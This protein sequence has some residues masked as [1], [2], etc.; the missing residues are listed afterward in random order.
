MSGRNYSVFLGAL[1]F[2]SSIITASGQQWVSQPVNPSNVPGLWGIAMFDTGRGVAVGGAAVSNGLSGVVRRSAGNDTWSNVPP[3]NFSPALSTGFAFWSGACSRRSSGAAWI[4]GQNGVLYKSV[5]YGLNW[6]RKTSGISGTNSLFDIYFKTL[7]EGM[8]VGAAG[9]AYYTSDGGDNWTAL[10]SGTS[11]ALYAVHTAGSV[12]YVSGANN[13]MLAFT[14]PATWT[15]LGSSLASSSSTQIEGLHFLDDNTGHYSGY[16]SSGSTHVWRTTNGGAS[17]SGF[18]VEPPVGSSTFYSSVFFL[19]RN[20]GWVANAFDPVAGTTNGGTTWTT[21]NPLGGGT[22]AITRLDFV[23]QQNG[24]ASGGALG[25]GP[26]P[27]GFI[28]KYTGPPPAPDIAGSDTE[29]DFGKLSCVLN[30]DARFVLRNTGQLTLVV[31]AG[32]ITLPSTFFSLVSPA[33]PLSIPPGDSAVVTLRWKPDSTFTGALA[34]DTVIAVSNDPDQP[35]WA[36]L[37]KGERDISGMQLSARNINFLPLCGRSF[38]DTVLTAAAIGNVPPKII[39]FAHLAG[40]TGVT[41]MSPP[42]GSQ[43]AGSFEMSFRLRTSKLGALSGTYRLLAGDP[44]CPMEF[45]IDFMAHHRKNTLTAAPA[46]LEFGEVCSG[47]TREMNVYLRNIGNTAASISDRELVSGIDAF[48]NL[49]PAGFGPIPPDSTRQYTARFALA[50]SDTGVI[51]AVYRLISGPCSDTLLLTMRGRAVSAALSTAPASPVRLGPISIGQTEERAVFFTNR[52]TGTMRITGMRLSPGS[53]AL[54]LTN[55]PAMPL[56]LKPGEESS[57]SINFSPAR[58]ETSNA[59]L[60]FIWDHPCLDS[61]CLNVIAQSAAAASITT[62][63]SFDFGLQ[64]CSP[65]LRDSFIVRSMGPGPLNLISFSIDGPD[66]AHFRVLNPATPALVE[67][68]DSIYIMVEYSSRQE[69]NSTATL[70]VSHNDASVNNAS[71]VTLTGSRTVT[72]FTVEGDSTTVMS[73]CLKQEIARF[74]TIRNGSPRPLDITE[75]SIAQGGSAWN[76]AG[77]ALPCALAPGG[78]ISFRLTFRPTSG[79]AIDGLVRIVSKPCDFT[80]VLKVS[81]DGRNSAIT[82]IPASINFSTVNIGSV[83][84]RSA[85]I[86]NTGQE[87]VTVTAVFLQPAVPA[88]YLTSGASVP[89]TLGTGQ[90]RSIELEFRPTSQG[91]LFGKL[92]VATSLPCPDTLCATTLG[93]ARSEGIAFDRDSIEA[94]HDACSFTTRCET[95]LLI[96]NSAR[97]VTVSDISLLPAGLFTLDP[98]IATPFELRNGDTKLLNICSDPGFTGEKHARLAVRSNDPNFPFIELPIAAVRDSSGITADH[99][100]LDFGVLPNC[101][102]DS[103]LTVS[104]RNTGTIDDTLVIRRAPISPFRIYSTGRIA[105]AAAAAVGIDVVFEPSANGVFS[106]TMVVTSLS[107]NRDIAMPL[108][109]RR[110]TRNCDVTPSPLIFSGVAVGGSLIKD[111]KARNLNLPSARI[112]GVRIEPVAGPFT[113]EG[114]LPLSLD[115]G[116]TTLLP[117][118]FSPSTAGTASGAACVIFDLPCA[119]TICVPLAGETGE[120]SLGFTT[121]PL[122]FGSLAQ[123]ESATRTDTLRNRGSSP[124][125]LQSSMITGAGAAGF[126]I[127]DPVVSAELLPAGGARSFAVR[128]EPRTAPDGTI[129]ASLVVSTSD[130]AQPTSELPLQGVRVTQLVPDI[131]EQAFGD[132]PLGSPSQLTIPVG[133]PGTSPYTI[134]SAVFD[135]E[136]SVSP[137]PPVTIQPGGAEQFMLT[138]TPSSPG[139]KSVEGHLIIG[140]PCPDTIKFTLT[141][142]V[143]GGIALQPINF[144]VTPV[145]LP[146]LSTTALYNP[147]GFNV[148]VAGI[149]IK[150]PDAARF[151]IDSPAAFP[152]T[153]RPGDSLT[154]EARFTPDPTEGNRSNTATLECAIPDGPNPGVVTAR[155]DAA[156]AIPL[157]DIVSIPDFGSVPIHMTSTEQTAVFYNALPFAIRISDIRSIDPL[158]AIRSILPVPPT[159]LQPGDTLNV[160]MDFS[161]V[162]DGD[163]SGDALIVDIDDPCSETKAYPVLGRGLDDYV[164]ADVS[165]PDLQGR[166]DERILAPVIL[167]TDVERAGVTGWEGS[168][169]FN[170]TM[171]FPMGIVTQGTKS[172]GMNVTARYDHEA[173][174]YHIQA[175]GGLLRPGTDTL[176][177][178]DFLVLLG[179]S[180]TS[181]LQLSESFDFTAGRA[182]IKN[183]R[184]GFFRLTDYCEADGSRM[185]RDRHGL[186]FHPPAPNPF[187]SSVQLVF[188]LEEDA[189]IELT[190]HDAMGR[191]LRRPAA[192]FFK[193]GMHKALLEA[194]EL[195]SGVYHA[196]LRSGKAE[197]SQRLILMR[198]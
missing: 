176:A 12:W 16:N 117:I 11:N 47:T 114:N 37:I 126:T 93:I 62:R 26:V 31:P 15:N 59:T 41:L 106:D 30:S 4:C 51:E 82:F 103:S 90:S 14:P 61:L 179:D 44:A 120:G 101:R 8:V 153:V 46:I 198:R 146:K 40:D 130:P 52:G 55:I 77:P 68:G 100:E 173:Q 184:N 182:R 155:L 70:T 135:P 139:G 109:G 81:G 190:I 108:K 169:N 9:A 188:Q 72:E 174:E 132:I 124:V 87:P 175:S 137:T 20:V 129:N 172:E 159:V 163:F 89:F 60:C 2:A 193:K 158:F 191:E 168:L 186:F 145:C 133:N 19:N 154:I 29:T 95:V 67:P 85:Q 78:T 73:T 86:T 80:H 148:T 98:S 94:R 91:T 79:G 99:A 28:L 35:R 50:P 49:Y 118:R 119:D 166:V 84:A 180:P 161:P 197:L 170:R 122:V 5:D 194:G 17:W 71:A 36:V 183:R 140:T 38:S 105:V 74:F 134:I 92:C 83:A 111:L 116:Q 53:A 195:P 113:F 177:F 88:V 178:V 160:I 167:S 42:V 22:G 142:N 112:A 58:I 104:I 75:L 187:A 13:T 6:T 97:I 157:P 3:A 147:Y 63:S 64:A 32:G 65:A 23:D 138:W 69:G 107:C 48:P 151:S 156:A 18:P 54:S 196:V 57:V 144:G 165:V 131:G 162:E 56:L 164:Y 24:W 152:V 7:N 45:L 181:V 127:L 189:Y 76:I 34:G 123:C 102:I 192:G 43:A 1:L 136:I 125:T 66:K 96:N 150:G 143:S 21:H 115:S 110:E 128:F 25:G 121:S 33:L 141:A 10:N 149:S 185:I 171:L 39:S 27:T